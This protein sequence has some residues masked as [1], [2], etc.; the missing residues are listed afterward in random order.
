MR[1]YIDMDGVLTD[2]V[3]HMCVS[4]GYTGGWPAGVYDVELA[5]GINPW[6]S[7]EREGLNFWTTMPKTQEADALMGLIRERDYYI[8]TAL[9]LDP[10]A[11]AGKLIW[12]RQHF[13]CVRNRYVITTHKHLLAKPGD[14]L[15]DD[16]DDNVDR[17]NKAGGR[18]LLFPRR[19]NSLYHISHQYE[20]IRH[21]LE[22]L[23]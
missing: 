18:G 6:K 5:T 1:I 23:L 19:W 17:W 3:G 16:S 22:G 12:L 21:H 9:T 10:M 8:C 2:F 11:A 20:Y 13:P 15:I 7:L 14:I 4:I